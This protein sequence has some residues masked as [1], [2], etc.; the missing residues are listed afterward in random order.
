MVLTEQM[1]IQNG[2]LKVGVGS[3]DVC[4]LQM[5]QLVL[6]RRAGKGPFLMDGMRTL[7]VTLVVMGVPEQ[8]NVLTL[9]SCARGQMVPPCKVNPT[10]LHPHA[11]AARAASAV[12]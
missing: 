7:A 4:A 9:Q 1:R 2:S 11:R 5:A 6:E 3:N 10:E 12:S 8:G